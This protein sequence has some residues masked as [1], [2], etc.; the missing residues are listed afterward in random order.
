MPNTARRRAPQRILNSFAHMAR[1][2]ALYLYGALQRPAPKSPSTEY[3]APR[4]F[5]RCFS[6]CA[7]MTCEGGAI[8]GC[9]PCGFVGKA[10]TTHNRDKG[11]P[12]R[13]SEVIAVHRRPSRSVAA[14]HDRVMR[15]QFTKK[16]QKVPRT[17]SF[18]PP[19]IYTGFCKG[20]AP[21]KHKRKRRAAL[22]RS[23][24]PGN[25]GGGSMMVA[26]WAI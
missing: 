8:C 23:Q 19:C 21:G 7:L 17:W 3:R 6:M 1:L 16:S 14:C 26:S 5:G 2:A 18:Y 15:W 22:D 20:R 25:A 24:Q 12:N 11:A 9:D 4:P 10:M 13:P